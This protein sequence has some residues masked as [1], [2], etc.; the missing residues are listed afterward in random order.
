MIHRHILI[1][2]TWPGDCV[3]ASQTDLENYCILPP[4]NVA[5]I[6]FSAAVVRWL[7]YG[8]FSSTVATEI[9]WANCYSCG[10]S[11]M[12]ADLYFIDQLRHENVVLWLTILGHQDS[13]S[14]AMRLVKRLVQITYVSK[15]S[16]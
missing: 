3:F 11:N 14:D 6:V 13:V 12:E 5:S 10:M 1:K 4:L 15:V 2:V 8:I 7:L 16:K 9:C